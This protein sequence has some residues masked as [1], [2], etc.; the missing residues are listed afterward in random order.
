M[1]L[2]RA[3]GVDMVYAMD[4][5][6]VG[7]PSVLAAK[8]LFK[9][10][11]LKVVGDYAWEQGS[12]R[13]GVKVFLDEFSEKRTGYGFL[14]YCLKK[15]Q[16]FVA[17]TADKIIVPSEYLK[18]IVSNWG[19]DKNKIKVIYNAF[20]D[21]TKLDCIDREILKKDLKIEGQIMLSVGRLVPWKGF[22]TL[23]II[24]KELVKVFPNLKLLIAGD[25]PDKE[26]LDELIVENVLADH[27]KLLGR[28]D[29]SILLKYLRAASVFVLNTSYEGFSHQLLETMAVGTPIVT[30]DVGGNPELIKN[31]KDGFLVPFDNKEEIV[32]TITQVLKNTEETKKIIENGKVRIKNFSRENMI[33]GLIK[34]LQ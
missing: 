29:H 3:R 21:K 20:E 24:M 9:K 13:S 11:Y 16:T 2:W 6:S 31:G 28:V 10:F 5:V 4:P 15:I 25:G 18:K 1:V 19:I 33:S 17:S 32:K 26:K 8:I 12:Q 27:I 23:I 7:L 34:E 22:D 30:T 14:V